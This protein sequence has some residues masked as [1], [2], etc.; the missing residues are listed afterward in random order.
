M[1]ETGIYKPQN[2]EEKTLYDLVLLVLLN[3]YKILNDTP[4]WIKPALNNLKSK[5]VIENLVSLAKKYVIIILCNIS[6][7][8]FLNF[9][10]TFDSAF[11]RLILNR[12]TN[13]GQISKLLKI[14]DI[15]LE[16]IISNFFERYMSSSFFN[17]SGEILTELI[18]K[19]LSDLIPKIEEKHNFR[20]NKP[21]QITM[22]FSENFFTER[23][24]RWYTKINSDYKYIEISK[25][26]D[27]SEF[28]NLESHSIKTSRPKPVLS[29]G[30]IS[31]YTEEEIFKHSI[32]LKNLELNK[33]YYYRICSLKKNKSKEKIY[34]FKTQDNKLNN[35]RFI[36]L[37][38]S[39]AMTK[40][41]YDIFLKVFSN[42]IT[43][44]KNPEFVA[45]LG[46]FVDDGNN[47]NYWEWILN[48][49]IWAEN[50]LIPLSGNH[51]ARKILLSDKKI[52]NSILRHF[53]LTDLSNQDLTT[54]AYYSY[55]YKNVLFI[56]LN[57]NNLDL[58]NNNL[59]KEQYDWILKVS[60]RE[61]VKFKIVFTHKSPYSNGPHYKN[62]D[63]KE[64][65]KQLIDLCYEF[66]IDLVISGHDHVYVRTPVLNLG[67]E[68][69][70]DEKM[71]SYKNSEFSVYVN[72]NGTLYVT[73]GTSGVK[74]YKQN[75]KANIPIE[76]EKVIN[77]PIYSEVEI[78]NNSL[79][80]SAYKYDKSSNSSKL[81]DCFAIEKKEEVSL[82]YL[83]KF[84]ESIPD[85]PWKNHDKRIIKAFKIYEK[86]SEQDKFQVKNYEKLTKISK[87]NSLY[88][89]IL[90]GETA[91]VK[92][93]KEFLRSIYN[94]KVTN[95][96]TDCEE[97]KFENE[98][99]FK[100]III[101]NRSLSIGGSAKLCYVN[102]HVK[103]GSIFLLKDS[104]CVDNTRRLFSLYKNL[105][106]INLY[107][108]AVLI[109]GDN[110]SINSGYG[111]G[112]NCKNYICIKGKN[113]SVY[114]NNKYHIKNYIYE[115]KFKTKVV[116]DT[117]KNE[118]I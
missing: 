86:L 7:N 34:R 90:S 33:I 59:S 71:I 91:I 95:I 96:I 87:I 5:E 73:P 105:S 104:I 14:F 27:F 12:K 69:S 21:F 28:L 116:I 46:D 20:G 26:K 35:F 109:L 60:K 85:C 29:L 16:R 6:E 19:F 63:V 62:L 18:S 40:T 32:K 74:N 1:S 84:I 15:N 111:L 58:I 108:N 57:T 48:S 23:N 8:I 39:Q 75:K 51:E 53:Y 92:S 89:R 83:N 2:S 24:L 11:L 22:T 67:Q 42:S 54:G 56:I 17:S 55:V 118:K 45:H 80:F 106:V 50:I 61:D 31:S 98:F 68:I 94:K 115:S 103:K 101:I 93:K 99:G 43:R 52:E 112:F 66:D 70:C 64:I 72:P 10:V 76:F 25:N 114:L 82:N 13:K 30:V 38:D 117:K 49:K 79:Y 77:F 9:K 110:S 65:G 97:I 37:A 44:I 36:V 100:N 78:K 102:F 113:T 41:D 88:K 47:E 81:L 107:E 4:K 3:Y